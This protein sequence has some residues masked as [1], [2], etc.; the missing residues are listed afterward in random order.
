MDRAGIVPQPDHGKPLWYAHFKGAD[1]PSVAVGV[2]GHALDANAPAQIAEDGGA[3][4]GAFA[5]DGW[6]DK[7]RGAPAGGFLHHLQHDLGEFEGGTAAIFGAA[8]GHDVILDKIEPEVCRV[9]LG[10]ACFP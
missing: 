10:G 8:V 9:C 7:A 6:Q 1:R 5:L 4:I 3:A 2:Q